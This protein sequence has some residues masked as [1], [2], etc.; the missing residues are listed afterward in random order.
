MSVSLNARRRPGLE[1]VGA[2]AGI[3]AFA[4]IAASCLVAA[5]AYTGARGEAYSP[6]SHWISELGEPGVSR[7][8]AV[9]SIDHDRSNVSNIGISDK[10]SYQ[11]LTLMEP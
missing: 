4:A 7:F 3:V 11:A 9:M 8:A 10:S 1:R 6:L 2:I 5:V